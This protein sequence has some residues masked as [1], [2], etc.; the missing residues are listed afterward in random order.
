MKVI[1][2]LLNNW[3]VA[4]V[5]FFLISGLIKRRGAAPKQAMPPF[6]DGGGTGWGRSSGQPVAAPADRREVLPPAQQRRSLVQQRAEA[7]YTAPVSA[8]SSNEGDPPA[9]DF[10]K[11]SEV[12]SSRP[13]SPD[14]A[15]PRPTGSPVSSF[16]NRQQ[17][18]DTEML[19]QGII[20]S[21]ILGPPRAKRPFRK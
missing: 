11:D 13:H 16:S 5:L 2:F 3:Y 10:W 9:A 14:R 12:K 18:I 17:T 15:E 1:E 4:I 8:A 19:A 21:E 7:P 20:W 6:G